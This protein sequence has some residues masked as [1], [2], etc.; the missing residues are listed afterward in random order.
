MRPPALESDRVEVK[1]PGTVD[2][3]TVGGGGRYLI[4]TLKRLNKLAVFDLT[5]SKIVDY[6][7][8]PPAEVRV[9]AGA[10]K[11][12]VVLVD[13]KLI[14][15]W[16]LSPLKRELTTTLPVDG[17][18][19]AAA[20]G[21]ASS[22]PLLLRWAVGT[23]ALAASKFEFFDAATLRRLDVGPVNGAHFSSFRDNVHVRAAA[24]GAAFGLWNTSSSPSGIG[25]ITLAGGKA[26]TRYEHNSG[27]F[28]VPGPD[29]RVVFTQAGLFTEQLRR[30]SSAGP[31]NPVVLSPVACFPSSLPGYYLTLPVRGHADS[32]AR[33]GGSGPTGSI[34]LVGNDRP[35]VSLPPLPELAPRVDLYGASDFTLDK[36]VHFLA[37][38]DLLV[39]IPDTND[40]LVLRKFDV[41]AELDK[42]GIDYLFV[43]STPVLSARKG[44]VYRYPIEVKSKRGGVTFKLESGPDGMAVS[45]AGVVTW[46]APPGAG[47]ASVI[48]T[49]ADASGQEIFH[50]FNVAYGDSASGG[51]PVAPG[52]KRAS[53]AKG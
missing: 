33:P 37:H 32:P 27:G 20:M 17:V 19:Q 49:V 13:Q 16:S 24:N 6:V 2:D 52:P 12:F 23:D 44:S 26:S 18:V 53:G 34:C 10:D 21:S 11:L 47:E 30:I 4:L 45:P 29:G 46:Q 43:S 22:G 7:P 8:I 40:A 35:L 5:A 36:R 41:L 42:S 31:S 25:V 1:L 9:A 14:Q 15:R 28:V 38:A 48:I 39:T 51:G 3:V 50:T